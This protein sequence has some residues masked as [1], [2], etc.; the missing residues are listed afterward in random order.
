[1]T[2]YL[3]LYGGVNE[4]GGNKFLLE[5]STGPF[6]PLAQFSMENEQA[7]GYRYDAK[8]STPRGEQPKSGNSTPDQHY[9]GDHDASIP[10]TRLLLDIGTSF[11]EEKEF[12]SGFLKPRRF[13]GISDQLSLGLLPA[14]PGVYREDVLFESDLDYRAPMLDAVILSHVHADHA[15]NL[16]YIDPAIPLYTARVNLPLLQFLQ[17]TQLA[18]EASYLSGKRFVP[19]TNQARLKKAQRITWQRTAVGCELQRPYVLGHTS[20]CFCGVD[21]SVPGATAIVIMTPD[22]L[23]AYTGDL[24]Q[25][26]RRAAE[27]SRFVETVQKLKAQAD[28]EGKRT[29]LLCEGTRFSDT[30]RHTEAHVESDVEGFLQEANEMQ[31]L[32]IASFSTLDVDRL[33][34]FWRAAKKVGRKLAVSPRQFFLLEKLASVEA[35][36]SPQQ[37]SENGWPDTKDPDLC[38]FFP[39]RVS[40]DFHTT[41]YEA[42]SERVW[43]DPAKRVTARDV[44]AAPARFVVY[45]SYTNMSSLLDFNLTDR[46]VFI[47][48]ASEPYDAEMEIID[49]VW[50]QWRRQFKLVRMNSHASGHASGPEIRD[51]IRA[52][53]PD[54]LFPVHTETPDAYEALMG[55]Q[56]VMVVLPEKGK[57]YDLVGLTR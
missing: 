37:W 20:V 3:T 44:S 2:T 56:G 49:Q 23:L 39:R 22:V 54:V 17:E 15:G 45:L 4:I 42:W 35:G 43:H 34:T 46:G 21:H 57:L 1:M 14:L 31:G 16:P 13:T 52:I 51:L 11:S 10:P 12:Y 41:D 32:A 28:E 53:Q 50:E 27:T 26:G 5:T 33:A 25:H 7:K 36:V 6:R 9:I 24:R 55:D 48:S 18:G 8:S 47:Y 38:V 19:R 30:S 29:V 40:G